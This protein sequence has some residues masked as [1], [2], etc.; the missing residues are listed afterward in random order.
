MWA[1]CCLTNNHCHMPWERK[2]KP[3]WVFEVSDCHIALAIGVKFQL[4]PWRWS[5]ILLLH[6]LIPLIKRVVLV[7]FY[8]RKAKLVGSMVFDV[9]RW[10]VGFVAMSSHI[11]RIQCSSIWVIDMMAM[12]ELKLYVFKGT[13]TKEGLICPM[14][15]IFPS[16]TKQHGNTN[17]SP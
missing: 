9:T 16:T 7:F 13:T 6:T 5:P 11:A 1:L 17:L 2:V 3:L 12:G 10:N 15:W 14:W 4:Q 8:G